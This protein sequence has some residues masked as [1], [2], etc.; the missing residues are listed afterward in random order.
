MQTTLSNPLAPSLQAGG[1]SPQLI[2]YSAGPSGTGQGSQPGGAAG[3]SEI[4][5]EDLRISASFCA[6]GP[7]VAVNCSTQ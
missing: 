3:G 7:N 6:L 2:I 4:T 1:Y 5:T